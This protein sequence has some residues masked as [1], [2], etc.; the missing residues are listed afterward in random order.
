MRLIEIKKICE[1]KGVTIRA[2]ADSIGMSEQNLHR[3]IT[4]NKIQAGDL[5]NIANTLGV[6]ILTFFESTKANIAI[7]HKVSGNG[8]KV[9]G[10]ISLNEC[11]KEIEHLKE[12]LFEKERIIQ[13]FIK[14]P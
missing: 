12:L 11:K 6:P 4:N 3:C 9:S 8:N 10:D 2:L 14:K 7:G 13:L 5:E 1:Q